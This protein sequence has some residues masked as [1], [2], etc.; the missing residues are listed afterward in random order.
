VRDPFGG[1]LAIGPAARQGPRLAAQT[2]GQVCEAC[3]VGARASLRSET[4]RL[5]ALH[6]RR[7][8]AS[9]MLPALNA[10]LSLADP[11]DR[12]RKACIW[13]IFLIP[14]DV[15]SSKRC[16]TMLNIETG[17]MR[18]SHAKSRPG[19]PIYVDVA[20][21]KE[22][23]RG[24]LKPLREQT[25]TEPS[26][27]RVTKHCGYSSEAL[28]PVTVVALSRTLSQ[29]RYHP[30]HLS[31]S[32]RPGFNTSLGFERTGPSISLFLLSP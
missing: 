18:L 28:C 24:A 32:H 16:A 30:L 14:T 11:F 25:A 23:D 17:R 31:R 7:I 29:K 26:A 10:P 2:L 13:H 20:K 5:P 21:V 6:L 9:R 19:E 27:P 4:L 22:S 8:R 12:R 15:K 3:P 1:S